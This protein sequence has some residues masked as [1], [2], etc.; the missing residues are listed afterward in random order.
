M[1]FNGHDL[2]VKGAKLFPQPTKTL[3]EIFQNIV[4]CVTNSLVSKI[5]CGEEAIWNFLVPVRLPH[6]VPSHAGV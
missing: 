2:K 5:V 3:T 6:A 1:I 4:Y